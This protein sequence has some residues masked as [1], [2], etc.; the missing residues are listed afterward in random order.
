[1]K[2]ANTLFIYIIIIFVIE[3]RVSFLFF[4]TVTASHKTF[5]FAQVLSILYG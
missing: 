1:M 5:Q 4:Q 2:A 3:R